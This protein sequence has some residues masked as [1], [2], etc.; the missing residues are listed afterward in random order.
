MQTTAVIDGGRD[1]HA[2]RVVD[3]HDDQPRNA[4][5]NNGKYMSGGVNH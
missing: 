2:C 4:W 5:K 3:E 1:F